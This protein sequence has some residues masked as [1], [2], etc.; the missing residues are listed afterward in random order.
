MT[1]IL[2]RYVPDGII[3][4]LARFAGGLG[5]FRGAYVILRSAWD[6]WPPGAVNT[7]TL[8]FFARAF[9]DLATSKVMSHARQRPRAWL[10]SSLVGA[11]FRSV[12]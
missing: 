12:A 7:E 4:A 6:R 2:I 10:A 3:A 8:G 5:L 1:D 11:D 9:G